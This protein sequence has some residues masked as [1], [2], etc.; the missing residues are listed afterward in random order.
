[1]V[2]SSTS[3]EDEG[4]GEKSAPQ[5]DT[6]AE[7]F[8]K[9][10]PYYLSI[11]MTEEQY[12]DKDCNLVK[13]YRKANELTMERLNLVAWLQ[14]RYVYD[15]LCEVSPIFHAFA[16]KGAKPQPFTKQPYPITKHNVQEVKEE[17]AQAKYNK[18]KVFMETF[19]VKN[20]MAFKEIKKGGEVNV[21]ND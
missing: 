21:N 8:E 4:S 1:M 13:H 16:K 19:A 15:A 17:K 5:R 2:S 18:N 12:W 10:F 11:G 20:N 7:T 14:G 3:S 6:Y 9:M